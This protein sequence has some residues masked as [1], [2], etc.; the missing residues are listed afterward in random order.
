MPTTDHPF[1]AVCE[2]IAQGDSVTL[3][4]QTV[5]VARRSFFAALAVAPENDPLH[6]CYARARRARA[7]SRADD[8]EELSRRVCLQKDDPDHLDPNA[9]RV[10][11]DSIKWLMGKENNS[12]YG[13]KVVL[14]APAKPAATREDHLRIVQESGIDLAAIL[15]C[16]SLPSV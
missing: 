10:A 9:A 7:D 14:E 2:H 1:L 13:D 3:A 11:M 8:L 5:G 12:R 6:H 16:Y 15:E 4:C